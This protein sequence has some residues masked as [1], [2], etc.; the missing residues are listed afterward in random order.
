MDT[1]LPAN[2]A[3]GFGIG[4]NVILLLTP[5]TGNTFVAGAAILRAVTVR[6]LFLL[7]AATAS[8]VGSR[9]PDFVAL[10]WI[11]FRMIAGIGCDGALFKTDDVF[12]TGSWDGLSFAV[13]EMISNEL[14]F[15]KKNSIEITNLYYWLK[16]LPRWLKQL[17]LILMMDTRFPY[18]MRLV[19]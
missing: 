3:I 16:L 10:D 11:G 6:A 12:D 5:L 7:I 8:F 2:F 19:L 13:K 1:P 18:S 14:L 15:K 4:L 9:S 17:E